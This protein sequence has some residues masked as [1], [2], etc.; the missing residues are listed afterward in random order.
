VGFVMVMSATPYSVLYN[1]SLILRVPTLSTFC[2]SLHRLLN[3]EKY[4]PDIY[5][6]RGVLV[7]D[8]QSTDQAAVVGAPIGDTLP[9]SRELLCSWFSVLSR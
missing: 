5:V 2:T 6:P 4:G 1:A 3:V 9:P 7:G 8:L